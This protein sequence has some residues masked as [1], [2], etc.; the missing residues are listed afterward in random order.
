M[1]GKQDCE[2]YPDHQRAGKHA[3]ETR[4]KNLGGDVR[5][6]REREISGVAGRGERG[7]HLDGGRQERREAGQGVNENDGTGKAFAERLRAF[8]TGLYAAT[9]RL[10]ERL[11]GFA[12]YVRA[13]TTGERATEGTVRQLESAGAEISRAG[14]P[15]ESVIYHEQQIRDEQDRA[16]Y[17]YKIQERVARSRSGPSMEL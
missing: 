4:G 5:Q 13:D 7:K 6:W 8:A 11:H 2:K 3:G 9:E 15:L 17:R 16:R 10:G 12:A 1:A 14:G